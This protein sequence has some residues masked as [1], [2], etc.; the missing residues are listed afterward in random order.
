MY[1]HLFSCI[2]FYIT[3][4]V[5]T[6]T[7]V[8]YKAY[9]SRMLGIIC[10]CFVDVYK[11]VLRSFQKYEVLNFLNIFLTEYKKELMQIK[12]KTQIMQVHYFTQN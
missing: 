1:L 5:N 6:R 12:N 4:T 9:V 11:F 7:C 3:Y 2:N 10:Y 8:V